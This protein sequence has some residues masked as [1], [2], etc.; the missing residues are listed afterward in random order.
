MIT[1]I[2]A[3]MRRLLRAVTLEGT[4]TLTPRRDGR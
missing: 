2:V 4:F 3:R 1:F